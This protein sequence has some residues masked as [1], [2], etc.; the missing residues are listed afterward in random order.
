MGDSLYG[1]RTLA[2][3]KGERKHNENWLELAKEIGRRVMNNQ[4]TE[5]N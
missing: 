4:K 5:M 2:C 1:S 3:V